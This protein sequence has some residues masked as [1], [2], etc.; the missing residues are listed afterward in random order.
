MADRGRPLPVQVRE[1]I[2]KVLEH[3]S[4]RTTAKVLEVSRNT[5]RKYRGRSLTHPQEATR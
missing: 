1:D 2:K 5:V 3:Q 4:I